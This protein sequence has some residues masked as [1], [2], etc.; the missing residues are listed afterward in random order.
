M[1]LEEGKEPMDAAAEGER[2]E[3]LRATRADP[4]QDV[5]P[6]AQRPCGPELLV[7]L[8]SY[9]SRAYLERCLQSLLGQQGVRLGRE[10][11]LLAVDNASSDGSRELLERLV[12]G[13]VLAL[14]R[15]VG[16]G[17]AL[18]LALSRS[19]APWILSLNPDVLLA[20]EFC[21]RVLLRLEAARGEP[22]LGMLAPKIRRCTRAEL[23][24]GSTASELLD[25]T[26]LFLDRARRPYDRGQGRP[27]RGQ[28]DAR[29]DV[30]GPCGAAGLYR[31]TMLEAVA[32]GGEAF[33][34]RLFLYWEDLDLAWRARR[35]GYVARLLPEA[36]CWHVRAAAD[37]VR[38]RRRDAARMSIA[39]RSHANRLLVLLKNESP[40]DLVR[41]L[42]WLLGYEL[43]RQLYV[44]GTQPRLWLVALGHLLR[45]AV[46]TWR[47]RRAAVRGVR[48]D[49]LVRR[50]RTEE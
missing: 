8:V 36:V 15:N 21:S 3:R 26:G 39:A 33:D 25:S 17:G 6:G 28:Y 4:R 49:G 42:P 40:W 37:L 31:R 43:A 14:E 9:Q 19:R 10:I 16:F 2:R 32:V 50:P 20:P 5:P 46:P 13:R 24:A 11:E 38:S 22:S 29:P 45:D 7:V 1:E 47:K 27:D 12:P 41:D 48:L 44:L 30:L 18:N 23:Q 34:E 35:A